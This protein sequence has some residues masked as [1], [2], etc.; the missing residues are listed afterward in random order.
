V[1]DELELQDGLLR[2]HRFDRKLLRLDDHRRRLVWNDRN[3]L[4]RG[5]VVAARV[6]AAALLAVALRLAFELL[7]Q[8]VDRRLHIGR[9]FAG[10]EHRPLRPDRRLG[11]LVLGD[12]RVLL[13]GKLELETGGLAQVPLELA[14]LRLRVALQRI[15]DL[16]VL[17]LHLES[18][19]EPPR[20]RLVSI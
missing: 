13:D 9:R 11:D 12:R 2:R 8:Q 15:V 5:V 14:E 6:G 20:R 4:G 17:A 1:A 7:H 10:A 19:S 3:R 16:D 18:H